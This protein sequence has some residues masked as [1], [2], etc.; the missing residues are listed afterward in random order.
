MLITIKKSLS[1][2]TPGERVKFF[3]LLVIRALVAFIDVVAIFAIGYLATSTTIILA[4]RDTSDQ[5]IT[6]GPFTIPTLSVEDLPFAVALVLALFV[7]KAVIAI[8]LTH[9]LAHLLALVE[10]RAARVIARNAFG[11]G[12]EG[13]RQ[14]SREEILFAVQA[15]SP[16]A[17]NGVLNS[18]GTLV[19]EGALFVLVLTSFALMSPVVAGVTL[20]YFGFVG[21]IIQFFI[22]RLMQRTGAKIVETTV[23]ANVGLS[24]LGEVLREAT[25]Q[26]RREFFYENIWKSRIESASNSATQVVLSGMPRYIIETSLIVG[27]TI[28]I[29]FQ[30]AS[31][32]IDSSVATLGVFLAGGLRLTASLLP[33]Q[34]ALLA[35][36]QSSPTANRALALLHMTGE[37]VAPEANS[38]LAKVSHE[39]AAVTILNCSYVYTGS[40]VPALFEVTI[41]IPK[42][43]QAAFI[44]PSGAGKSTLADVILGLVQPTGGT[45]H[46][47][48]IPPTKLIEANLGYMGYVP[49]K[50]GMVTGTIAQNIA[51]GVPQAEIN[52]QK[53]DDAI[54]QSNLTSFVAQ[55]PDGVNTNLGKRKDAL[56]GGQL[57]RIG[58]ARALY[59]EPRL[60]V[61]D[62][63][64]SALDAESEN[65]INIALENLRGKI[66]VILIA[67]RLN[68]VQKSD[69][70]FLIEEGRVSASGS[71]QSL[72]TSNRRVKNL[73]KLMSIENKPDTNKEM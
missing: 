43:H 34:G 3:T 68:T 26:G 35:I 11:K 58:L 7:A 66:T 18:L 56:S 69:I 42:G 1:F 12:L 52:R 49:Q 31:G 55:L 6:L 39:P 14:H 46:V 33:L 30:F 28:F 51:L 57:Q 2:M 47:D 8:L 22:G 4:Q 15:G 10:A 29:F 20:V 63:A 21:V 60:L 37:S 73:V 54:S 38:N 70:V 24:D 45:V 72:L 17:F 23:S 27:I 32:D 67:H 25:I 36:K 44:G 64:T 40:R 13:L 48:G 62:E 16:S 53:L 50:P 71:F 5:T 41:Q 65:E 9:K 61:L 19:A 59:T